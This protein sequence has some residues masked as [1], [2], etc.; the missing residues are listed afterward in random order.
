[1]IGLI[2]SDGV[3]TDK[4]AKAEL[5]AV[6]LP[7]G[8]T[9]EGRQTC[10]RDSRLGDPQGGVGVTHLEKVTEGNMD[11]RGRPGMPWSPGEEQLLAGHMAGGP[12]SRGSG[13]W[14]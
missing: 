1:M 3:G 14:L 6:V 7:V 10:S 11:R 8:P 4:R 12:K 9:A 13:M 2:P 5:A